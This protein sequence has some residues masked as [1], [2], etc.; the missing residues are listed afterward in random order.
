MIQAVT[1]LLK[2]VNNIF[3][4]LPR[5]QI[6]KVV[7]IYD[8]MHKLMEETSVERMLILKT[9]NGGGLIKP[10]TPLYISALYEDYTTPLD[11][12]KSDIQNVLLDEEFIRM[13]LELCKFKVYR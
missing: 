3:S 4:V 11:S 5:K 1:Q 8:S 9:H 7:G 13:M 12:V 6:E 2:L 10:S